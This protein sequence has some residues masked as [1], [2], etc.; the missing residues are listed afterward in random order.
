MLISE[1][2]NELSQG[3]AIGDLVKV[4]QY[5]NFVEKQILCDKIVDGSI[6]LENNMMV[7]NHYAKKINTDL[8]IVVNYTNLEFDSENTVGD[9]DTLCETGVMQY[10]LEHINR[11]EYVFI[12]DMVSDSIRSKLKANNSMES[13]VNN[14]LTALL[15]KLP[16][17]KGIK[18]I[19]K[20][21]SKEFSKFDPSKL[22]TLQDMLSVTQGK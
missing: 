2:K 9:Y 17:E 5:L 1:I 7:C 13:V 3:K 21:A 16:D 18:S 11:E 14:A 15:S 4:S 6:D 19:M 8:A 20:L 10:I 12:R 22:K